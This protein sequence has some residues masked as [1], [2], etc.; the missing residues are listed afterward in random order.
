MSISNGDGKYLWLFS[1]SP[2]TSASDKASMIAH[3]QTL[4]YDT[5]RL[6]YDR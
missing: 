5:S 1:R 4:G 6:I 3:A 2:Q